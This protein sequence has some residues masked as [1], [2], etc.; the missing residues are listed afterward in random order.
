MSHASK[1]FVIHP[2]L[3]CRVEVIDLNYVYNELYAKQWQSPIDGVCHVQAKTKTIFFQISMMI[4]ASLLGKSHHKNG[5]LSLPYRKLG[6]I[7]Q[8]LEQRLH[9]ASNW[10]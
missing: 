4:L 3:V 10:K 5:V 2:K 9:N 6:G 1:I 7:F 8:I